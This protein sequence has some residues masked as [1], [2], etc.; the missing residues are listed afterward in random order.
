MDAHNRFAE[1]NKWKDEA[2]RSARDFGVIS[3]F[4]GLMTAKLV[5]A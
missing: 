4:I 3:I 2:A 1:L 5:K